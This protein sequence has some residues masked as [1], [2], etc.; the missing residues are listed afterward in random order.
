MM[1]IVLARMICGGLVSHWKQIIN[2]MLLALMQ[3]F[4]LNVKE[5][6]HAAKCGITSERLDFIAHTRSLISID[7]LFYTF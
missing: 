2:S 4:Y 6:C 1:L 5:N 7:R 3:L